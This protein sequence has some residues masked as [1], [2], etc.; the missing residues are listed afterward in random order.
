MRHPANPAPKYRSITPQTLTRAGRKPRRLPGYDT[1]CEVR[2]VGEAI[3]LGRERSRHRPS[4]RATGEYNSLAF[5]IRNCRGIEARQW[6]DN[7]LGIAFR[8]GLI[9]LSYVNQENAPLPQTSGNLFRRKVCYL[10]RARIF[11]G[12]FVELHYSTGLNQKSDRTHFFLA[13]MVT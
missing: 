11:F 6:H 12:H 7:R 13:Q 5:G 3:V 4:S 8:R 1:A 10:I 9:R 2:L